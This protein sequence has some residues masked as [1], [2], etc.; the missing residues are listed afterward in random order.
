MLARAVSNSAD[1]LPSAIVPGAVPPGP[2]IATA[3]KPPGKREGSRGPN[4]SVRSVRRAP[5]PA[6]APSSAATQIYE[7]LWEDVLK[8]IG[9]WPMED[10]A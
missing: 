2:L 4:V 3:E 10:S 8:K 5:L 1:R 9:K 7:D 6:Y